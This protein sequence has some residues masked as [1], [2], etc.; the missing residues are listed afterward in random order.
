MERDGM[1]WDDGRQQIAATLSLTC[2]TCTKPEL[3]A[4]VWPTNISSAALGRLKTP[5]GF[6]RSFSIASWLCSHLV[7]F[8][9]LRTI[10]QNLSSENLQVSVSCLPA[11]SWNTHTAVA[12][13]HSQLP[14]W[15][16][17]L[18]SLTQSLRP[19]QGRWRKSYLEL[20]NSEF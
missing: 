9:A 6:T 16:W 20:I 4:S 3:S 12:A 18:G 10:F 5:F 7:V 2:Q 14:H 15:V 8:K 13:H 1:G 19:K 11:S 17:D